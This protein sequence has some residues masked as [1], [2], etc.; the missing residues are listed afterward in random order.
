MAHL[1]KEKG[2]GGG[3]SMAHFISSSLHAF[4]VFD[5]GRGEVSIKAKV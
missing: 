5:E 3:L 1:G 2:E 4:A